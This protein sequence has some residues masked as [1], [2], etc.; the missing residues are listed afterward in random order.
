M[1]GAAMMAGG[2]VFALRHNAAPSNRQLMVSVM[3]VYVGA[4]LLVPTAIP[5][6]VRAAAALH[7]ATD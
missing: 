4:L 5:Y 2:L 6:A 7:A 1:V 3:A